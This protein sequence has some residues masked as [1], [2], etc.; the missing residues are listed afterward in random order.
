MTKRL[1]RLYS[2]VVVCSLFLP[3]TSVRQC[4]AGVCATLDTTRA[5][6]VFTAS[7]CGFN[8]NNWTY[9]LFVSIALFQRAAEWAATGEVTLPLPSDFPAPDQASVRH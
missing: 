6:Q 2:V 1:R 5:R 3:P 4:S 7:A 9:P 8:L